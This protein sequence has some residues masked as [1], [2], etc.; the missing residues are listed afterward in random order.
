[1]IRKWMT[2]LLAMLLAMMLPLCALADTQ[3]ILTILPG[4]ALATEQAVADL[5]KVLSFSLTTGKESGALTIGLDGKD[6]LTAAAKADVSGLYVNSNIL[7]DDVLYVTWEDGFA[8]LSQALT[9][10]LPEEEAQAFQQAMAE[11]QE[12]VTTALQSGMPA[13][14]PAVVTPAE[15]LEQIKQMYPDDPGLIKMYENMFSRMVE[16]KGEFAAENRDTATGKYS[17]TMTAEDLVAVC[18]TKLMRSS[19]EQMLKAENPEMSADELAKAVDAVLDEVREIYRNTDLNAV[20][21]AY[22]VDEGLTLVGMEMTMPMTMRVEEE[23]FS[24][25]ANLQYNRLTDAN[26]VS[27]KADMNIILPESEGGNVAVQFDLYRG[28]DHVSKGSL[29]LLAGGAEFT[30]TYNA[31]NNGDVRTRL[32]EVYMR[33]GAAAIIPPAASD[34]PLIGFQVITEPADPAVLAKI[35]AADSTNAVNVMKLSAEE[36]S[37]L[38]SDVE[39]RAMQLVFNAMGSLPASVLTMLMN[40]AQ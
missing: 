3:H 15:G 16:E 27:Y 18:D 12:Q 13:S 37:A 1:M 28:A 39:A 6:L 11:A 31:A 2:T 4:D 29:A 25:D 26:G 20:M 23:A 22:T 24:M 32:A 8:V 5:C 40:T 34:R 9:A 19:I 14:I 17:M 30:I 10:Q 38:G 35:E 36:M 21:T 7:S 33:T